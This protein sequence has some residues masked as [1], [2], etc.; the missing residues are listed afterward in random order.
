MV[1]RLCCSNVSARE[2]PT[3]IEAL[4]GEVLLNI[5]ELASRHEGHSMMRGT[6]P[7]VCKRW[8]DAIYGTKGDLRQ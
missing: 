3:E 1:G 8:K 4:S 7:L 5:L 2:E 6:L